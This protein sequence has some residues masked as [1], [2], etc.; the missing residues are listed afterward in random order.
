[1]SS[2]PGTVIG[3]KAVD[4]V[5]IAAEK[6]MTY[7]GFVLSK[8]TRK[9]FPIT[10]HIGIGFA[11]LVGDMQF[12]V[13]ALR[14]EAKNY[15]LQNNREIKV[16]SLAKILSIIL[17]SYKL[18]PLLTEIVV[19]GVDNK[20]PQIF[21]LDPVGSLIEDKYAALG[22]GGPVAIGIIEK[23]YRDD[24]SIDEVEKL[25][26]NAIRGAIERDA[27]SGDG[28]DILR[29]TKDGYELKEFLL[30]REALE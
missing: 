12:V 20:G 18:I 25:V 26:I 13:R 27:V 21:V 14:M 19:G 16:R 4:G 17:Y 8:N 23:E 29:I 24:M 22:S 2:L 6:R 30:K 3:V 1:M 15:E 9:V 5:V 7:D 10:G 11:G 28:L